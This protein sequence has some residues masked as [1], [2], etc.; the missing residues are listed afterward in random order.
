MK[1]VTLKPLT[2]V[3]LYPQQMNIYGDWGNILILTQRAKWHGYDM[4]IIAH[5]PGKAFP[6][7]A[8]IVVGGG[9]QDSGQNVIQ[10]DLL[11]IGDDIK[12]LANDHVPMLVICGLYQLFGHFFQT[13]DGTQI[14][15]I[16]V[17]DIETYGGDKRMIG[18]IVTHTQFGEMIGYENH[19]GMTILGDYQKPLG[20]VVKGD[21]NNGKDRTEGAIYKHVFG[22]YLHG[23]L[24]PKNPVFADALIEY[25]AL[26][27]YGSFEPTIIDD[28]FADAAR[29]IAVDRP[30]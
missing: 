1:K 11:A 9:G 4:Q 15:G 16:G 25:A 13:N 22:S 10:N 7:D 8:D 18:N 14:R 23:S 3:H 24:L 5:H 28:R 26:H 21:G 12:R 30:R 27:R 2:L 17:F 6:R 20:K 29:K 19:S